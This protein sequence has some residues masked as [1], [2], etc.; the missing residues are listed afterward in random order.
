MSLLNYWPTAEEVNSCIKPEAEGAPESV[1]LAVHQPS[2][3]S[4]RQLPSGEKLPASEDDLYEYFM[5]ANVPTGAH[6][7]PITGSSG[8]GKSHLVRILAAR[9]RSLPQPDRYL[10]IRIPKSASLR[11]VVELILAPLPD[12]QYGS[13]KQEFKKALAEIT[14]DTAVISFQA[15]LEIALEDLAKDLREQVQA[16]PTNTVLKEQLAHARM[17]PKFLADASVVDHIRA[18]VLSK[19]VKRAVAGQSAEGQSASSDDFCADDFVL[20][21]SIDLDRDASLTVRQYYRMQMEAREGH[22]RRVAANLLNGRVVDQ[23][24]RQLFQLHEAMGGMTL[25]D[26]ILEIRRLLLK[27]DREL[28]ILVEDF[29]ALTGIQETLLNVLIQEGVRDGVR[30]FATMRSAIAVTDGYLTGKDTIATRA[31]RE[32]IVESHLRDKEEVLQ[33][34]TRLVAAYLNAARWGEAALARH[35][36]QRDHSREN[37]RAWIPPYRHPD[38]GGDNKLVAFGKVD[39][40]PLF[41]FTTSAIACLAEMTLRQGDA[42][43]FTPRLIIDHIIRSPLLIGRGA[44][45]EKRFPPPGFAGPANNADVSQWLTAQ[46]FT[47]D[48]RRRYSAVVSIWGNQPQSRADIGRIPREVF[49]AFDLP[50][51]DV[52]FVPEPQQPI[53]PGPE[54]APLP[55]L[56]PGPSSEE[57]TLQETLERWVQENERLP[58]RIANDIRKELAAAIS[59]R[60][61]WNGERC[62]RMPLQPDRISI[63]NAQGQGGVA[64]QSLQVAEDNRDPTGRLRS[65]L[66]ALIRFYKFRKKKFDYPE[67]DDDLARVG[68]LVSR[69]VPEARRLLRTDAE[70]RLR[71]ATRALVANSRLLGI[72]ERGRTPSSLIAFLF[73]KPQLKERSAEFAPV[74]YQE[75]RALQDEA[76][77]LRP[78]LIQLVL[79]QCGCFQG[80]IG[81]IAYG[82]DI[83]RVLEHLAKDDD[84][85]EPELIPQ[86][87]RAQVTAMS[88]PRV[89]VRAKRVLEEAVRIASSLQQELGD[90]IAKQEVADALKELGDEMSD[91]GGWSRDDLGTPATFKKLCE[92]FRAAALKESLT[93]LQA[94]VADSDQDQIRLITR[95]AQLDINPMIIAQRFVKEGRTVV[96]SAQKQVQL[97]EAQ[98]QG[99]DPATQA[100]SIRTMFETLLADLTTLEAQGEKTCC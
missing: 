5:T 4:Y 19:V 65:E 66:M 72:N 13:V 37:A 79:A 74:T 60:I 28:V 59:E 92:A 88:E 95:L 68:N 51:P 31:K 26:V 52:D 33:R 89:V 17:L 82:V 23:A 70:Q 9:L 42:L 91:R 55:T 98:S 21:D 41:P 14:I 96:T 12:N 100:Q 35:Y 39:D 48:Q 10:V 76:L 50:V 84:R 69:L 57:R 54:P 86:E 16:N 87:I 80:N 40:T 6:V 90:D 99:I 77:L 45:D 30:E 56:P 24:T 93:T 75:W 1:L 58:S 61:D 22:G 8:V 78:S 7:V 46:P 49:Q 18:Q 71:T 29:K 3:L 53:G 64:A 20:P 36:A 63:P 83:M 85:A 73:G 43:V 81:K 38:D 67:A 32:W 62:Q 25:Q 27:S 97:L 15:Q 34:T 2:P 11:S 94:S 47:A 44:F